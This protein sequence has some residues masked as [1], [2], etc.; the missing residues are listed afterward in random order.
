MRN[1]VEKEMQLKDSEMDTSEE[2][3]RKEKSRA[4]LL[5]DAKKEAKDESDRLRKK[6]LTVQGDL[7]KLKHRSKLDAEEAQQKIKSLQSKVDA[8]DERGT[9]RATEINELKKRL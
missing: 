4:A 5:E 1:Q 3:A 8:G 9:A 2:K 6:L 7:T